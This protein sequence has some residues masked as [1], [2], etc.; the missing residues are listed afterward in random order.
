MN[1]LTNLTAAILLSLST[2]AIEIPKGFKQE[3]VQ[4]QDGAHLNVYKG[5]K[6]EALVL[7]HGYAESALM[8]E[9]AMT[10]FSD[11]YTVIAPDLRGAGLSDV[12][13]TGYTKSAMAKDVKAILDHYGITKALIVGHDIGLMVAFAFAAQ[14]PTVTEKLVVMDAFLPGVGP[15]DD[16][17]NSPDIWHFRFQGPYAEELVKGRER[18]YLNSLWDGF[19]ANPKSFP[20]NKRQYFAKQYAQPG[21]M[22][23]GFQWFRT[24][25]N[26]ESCITKFTKCCASKYRSLVNGRKSNSNFRSF[27]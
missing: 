1:K 8:W 9:K 27:S 11:K 24:D 3:S 18:T 10:Q 20:E 6:G 16:I 21:H 14:Y 22:K 23:A 25:C 13:A 5:G 15:G 26:D 19:S 7:I 4:I 17:Y 2:Q 12:T